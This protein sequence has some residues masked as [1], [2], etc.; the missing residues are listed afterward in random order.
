MDQIAV[1]LDAPTIEA[2]QT[3]SLHP[4][5]KLGRYED[6]R[7][8]KFAI[9]RADVASWQ[10]NLRGVQGGRIAIDYDHM[11]DS[12]G[13]STKAAGWITSLQ[14]MT[15]AQLAGKVPAYAG[16]VDLG[17]EYAVASIDWTPEGAESVRAGYWLYVSPTFSSKYTNEQ[18]V[19]QGPTLVGTALTNRPFLRSGMPAIALTAAPIAAGLPSARAVPD[20]DPSE[21]RD[22]RGT[23]PE[24][25]SKKLAKAL[26]LAEDATE[27]QILEAADEAAKRPTKLDTKPGAVKTLEQAAQDEGLVLLNADD[28]ASLVAGA[29]AGEESAEKLRTL[30]FDGAYDKALR[31]G[32]L[33]SD[34]ET[35]EKWEGR[36]KPDSW[37]PDVT[38]E[39]L[40]ELPKI[41]NLTATGD[42]TSGSAVDAPAGADPA[43]FEL[44]K[45]AKEI[46]AEQ[47]IDL[48]Q[49]AELAEK[50]LTA[51]AA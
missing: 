18:E 5:A 13:G 8:G 23:M 36:Y 20:D 27:A 2:E 10:K 43:R 16:T 22:S 39:A 35:R 15:G 4:V 33:P 48:V 14:L 1:L 47:K 40:S 6:P 24:D 19:D 11:A 26:G 25:F 49:A 41:V 50:E 45:R 34:K 32:R 51:N 44:H 38:L 30:E 17:G 9:T 37:G 21:P 12:V 42:S 46:A 28:H 7:Y 31:E 29:K 3:R